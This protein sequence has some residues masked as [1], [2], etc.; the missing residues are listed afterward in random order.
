MSGPVVVLNSPSV[1]SFDNNRVTATSTAN[2][3]HNLIWFSL[4][5]T[6]ISAQFRMRQNFLNPTV[7]GTWQV[8]SFQS[9]TVQSTGVFRFEENFISQTGTGVNAAPVHFGFVHLT[10]SP[11]RFEIEMNTIHNTV[12]AATLGYF[13]MSSITTVSGT[14]L[15]VRKNEMRTSTAPI[16]NVVTASIFSS[17][18]TYCMNFR[19]NQWFNSP[20]DYTGVTPAALSAN[21]FASVRTTPNCVSETRSDCIIN[22]LTG[23]LITGFIDCPFIFSRC[24]MIGQ[25]TVNIRSMSR[26]V[27]LTFTFDTC[28]LNAGTNIFLR[29]LG[30][31]TASTHRPM[32]VI[33]RL[34]NLNGP[35]SFEANFSQGS[36][37]QFHDNN[38]QI[39][40]FAHAALTP[41]AT[42]FYSF[43]FRTAGFVESYILIRNSNFRKQVTG[44][45]MANVGYMIFDGP[46]T[47]TNVFFE[48][49][50]ITMAPA[51]ITM[52]NTETVLF[53]QMRV[54]GPLT[55][56]TFHFSQ[57]NLAYGVTTIT[58]PSTLISFLFTT[59]SNSSLVFVSNTF[60]LYHTVI[61]QPDR[62]FV[63]GSA[64]TAT[65]NSRIRFEKNVFNSIFTT[66]N[67]HAPIYFSFAALTFTTG[68]QFIFLMNQIT[69]T[70]T[71]TATLP[72][73]LTF[74]G[75]F[76]TTS[77]FEIQQNI[78]QTQ[79]GATGGGQYLC[80]TQGY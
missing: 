17:T 2:V 10:S 4:G 11:A 67:S 42:V 23:N 36:R 61:N 41:P 26:S 34:C 58:T 70:T 69:I 63:V 54:A 46:S 22:C 31:L 59:F 62:M 75:I 55:G 66:T 43:F 21:L 27:G 35:V 7:S 24:T 14:F 79:C 1:F 19:I 80:E 76:L 44:T 57:V 48:V 64:L 45:A 29:F 71:A 52:T 78:I 49:R 50:A 20:G 56:T 32:T 8:V 25:H 30:A 9:I 6:L 15:S 60:S 73:V 68:S 47:W 77:R 12:M 37:I 39:A 3:V 28:T 72:I 65:A 74:S 53:L 16:L 33:V 18:A 5:V 40:N 13:R 51:L 38:H